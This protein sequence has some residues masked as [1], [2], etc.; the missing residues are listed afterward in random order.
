LPN[1]VSDIFG[2]FRRVRD[3]KL[4][5]LGEVAWEE[6][7]GVARGSDLKT[8]AKAL[9]EKLNQQSQRYHTFPVGD[10]TRTKNM[11]IQCLK[12][13]LWV[14]ENQLTY[15]QNQLWYTNISYWDYQTGCFIEYDEQ[16]G[17]RCCYDGWLNSYFYWDEYHGAWMAC[18]YCDCQVGAESQIEDVSTAAETGGYGTT[19]YE[20]L[21]S[22]SLLTVYDSS[23][24]STVLEDEQNDTLSREIVRCTRTT[25]TIGKRLGSGTFG[26]VYRASC[27]SQSFALKTIRLVGGM[28]ERS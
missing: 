7:R 16:W 2:G 17:V 18:H 26:V 25:I 23:S 15:M 6:G 11:Q 21:A 28:Y 5:K 9:K 13:L 14:R 4:A 20:F 3:N 19:Y 10:V 12:N 22:S 27:R 24:A 1:I 8:D